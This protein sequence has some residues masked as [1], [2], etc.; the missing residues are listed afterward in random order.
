MA[1]RD[2]I[3]EAFGRAEARGRRVQAER[4][5][6]PGAVERMLRDRQQFQV[7]EAEVGGVGNQGFGEA[8]PVEETAVLAAPPGTE[9]DFVDGDRRIQ[10]AAR[11]DGLAFSG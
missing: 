7:R 11:A 2:E 1:G 10:P 4:L 9:M 5:V 8:P 6:A 3:A